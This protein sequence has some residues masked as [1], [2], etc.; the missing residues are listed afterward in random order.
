MIANRILCVVDLNMTSLY[1]ADWE[2]LIQR[3]ENDDGLFRKF[4]LLYTMGMQNMEVPSFYARDKSTVLSSHDL[5]EEGMEI[6]RVETTKMVITSVY[7]PPPTPFSGPHI[8]NP[9]NKPNIII[10]DFNSHNTI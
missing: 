8:T 9:V 5:S 7:K 6:L 10:G 2:D 4:Y 1:A 3:M